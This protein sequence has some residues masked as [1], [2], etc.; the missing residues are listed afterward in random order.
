MKDLGELNLPSRYPPLLPSR[1]Q[2]GQ[3]NK[4][5]EGLSLGQLVSW[6]PGTAPPTE[7]C[8]PHLPCPHPK[9]QLEYREGRRNQ[10][11]FSSL[12]SPAGWRLARAVR[13]LEPHRQKSESPLASY[14]GI[15]ATG[16][17]DFCVST[18][19][20]VNKRISSTSPDCC[21]STKASTGPN[22]VNINCF[23]CPLGVE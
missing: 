11:C 15:P 20:G 3:A 22:S 6:V 18:C 16:Y 13:A 4:L 10:H 1:Q 12:K 23:H 17:S 21:V 7:L 2:A 14:C 19:S 5:K 9:M 8:V